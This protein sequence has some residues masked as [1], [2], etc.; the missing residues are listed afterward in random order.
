[1]RKRYLL[2][3]V[4]VTV[5]GLALL[6]HLFWDLF[7][8]ESRKHA[9]MNEWRRQ[10]EELLRRIEH[11]EAPNGSLPDSVGTNCEFGAR[12]STTGLRCQGNRKLHFHSAFRCAKVPTRTHFNR[13][14]L[15]RD[16]FRHELTRQQ[17]AEDAKDKPREPVFPPGALVTP[18][19]LLQN[20]CPCPLTHVFIHS[21]HGN[22]HFW[23]NVSFLTL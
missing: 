1:M 23:R 18:P 3:L 14:C 2:L 16:K 5:V 11:Y 13:C 9:E 21:R 10:C 17:K 6:Q 22:S 8:S 4:F 20:L 7:S 15:E 12:R 19:Q